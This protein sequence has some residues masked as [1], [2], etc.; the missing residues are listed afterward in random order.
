MTQGA[1]EV[2]NSSVRMQYKALLQ[3]VMTI[4]PSIFYGKKFKFHG[5]FCGKNAGFHGIFLLFFE[6]PTPLTCTKAYLRYLMPLAVILLL[7]AM[8]TAGPDRL[9]RVA[10]S[11]VQL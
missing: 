1:R 3:C 9:Y 8:L 7:I 2:R 4:G 6:P 5:G 10:R 11:H